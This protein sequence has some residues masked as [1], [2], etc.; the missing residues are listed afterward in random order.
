MASSSYQQRIAAGMDKY[1]SANPGASREN[2]ADVAEARRFA[3]GHGST[4]E[5]GVTV[6]PLGNNQYAVTFRDPSKAEQAMR[7]AAKLEGRVTVTA[8]G[9]DGQPVELFANKGH[10]KGFSSGEAMQEAAKKAG[11][12]Q[13]FMEDAAQ[14]YKPPR[15]EEDDD[16][17][18]QNYD[19][20]GDEDEEEDEEEYDSVLA[21]ISEYQLIVQ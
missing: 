18:G 5:H 1:F 8:I 4:G 6:R 12:W 11:G 7:A 10:S 14:K 3:R 15:P 16:E 19:F 9:K 21:G 20:E 2:K 13:Q 17:D